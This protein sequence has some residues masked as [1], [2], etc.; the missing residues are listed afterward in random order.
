[1]GT[2][3]FEGTIHRK[4][5]SYSVGAYGVI[6]NDPETPTSQKLPEPLGLAYPGEGVHQT[7]TMYK[8]T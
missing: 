8:S 3:C 7:G 4:N 5:I 1:V 6:I 2:G